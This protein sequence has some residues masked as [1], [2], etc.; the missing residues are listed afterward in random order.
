MD[1]SKKRALSLSPEESFKSHTLLIEDMLSLISHVG[2]TSNLRFDP[3]PDSY[4]LVDA[5]VYKLPVLSENLGQARAIGSG[6]ATKKRI[7]S[8]ERMRLIMLSGLIK[9]A[10]DAN[11]RNFDSIFREAPELKS[12][13]KK[14]PMIVPMP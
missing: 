14:M 1:C 11:S 8:D 10:A 9:S 13:L 2:E 12:K 6:I 3:H 7:V 4:Y 5:V